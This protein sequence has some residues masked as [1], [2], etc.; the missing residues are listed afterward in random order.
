MKRRYGFT[1]IEL[2][3][4]IAI[5]SILASIVVPN[6][7]RYIAKGRMTKAVSEIRGAEVAV[8]QML[9]DAEVNSVRNFYSKAGLDRL[10]TQFPASA[11]D[12]IF[13]AEKLYTQLFYT[14]L[15]TGR[16]FLNTL[17]PADLANY[18]VNAIK[19]LGPGYMDLGKD[20]WGEMY[21]FY[22]G[23]YRDL[24][25]A[26]GTGVWNPYRVYR[27]EDMEEFK[28][29]L[30]RDPLYTGDY[31][32]NDDETD[33]SRVAIGYEAPKN[34]PVYIYST[35]ADLISAQAI[36][37]DP[38]NSELGYNTGLAPSSRGGGDD[39]NS[40]DKTGSWAPFYR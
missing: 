12:S 23:P 6:V 7:G 33:Q 36:Y 10:A 1:L 40:W 25:G 35:G 37:E 21:R 14:L 15:R 2:L 18:N 31:F 19:K 5:I 34:L 27:A 28:L 39:V 3:V 11:P 22:A 26:S 24:Q 30:R 32:D 4:V 16:E 29:T 17:D 13:R 9:A 38:A 20:P 8:T